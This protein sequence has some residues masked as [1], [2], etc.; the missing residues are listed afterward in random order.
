VGNAA[1][2]R[3]HLL[4]TLQHAPAAAVATT[5]RRQEQQQQYQQ[6]NTATAV[7]SGWVVWGVTT[8]AH[9]HMGTEQPY[10]SSHADDID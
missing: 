6:Q 5:A 1:Q 7:L 4:L 3:A 2:G 9:I 10:G 8:H